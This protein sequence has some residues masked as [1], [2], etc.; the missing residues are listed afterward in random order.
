MPD[1][2]HIVSVG[3]LVTD[4]EGNV[5]IGRSAT[6]KKWRFF[7]GQ[8]EPGENIEEALL[9]RIEEESGVTAQVVALAGVYSR[10][11]L[12]RLDRHGNPLPT[13]LTLDF[14]CAYVCGE[15]RDT[16]ETESVMWAP[17][18]TARALIDSQPMRTRFENLAGFQGRV[19]Y[20]SYEAPPFT[21]HLKRWV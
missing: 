10:V 16:C 11:G 2:T 8:V 9:R 5:L 17:V 7:G 3:G 18:E 1:P 19:A 13:Q 6:G 12:D 4:S 15:P 14:V 21:E 20:L